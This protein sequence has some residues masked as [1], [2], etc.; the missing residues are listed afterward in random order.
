[1]VIYH[2]SERRPQPSMYA[3]S[4]NYFLP[5][6]PKVP[7]HQPSQPLIK[8]VKSRINRHKRRTQTANL[9][10]ADNFPQPQDS[11]QIQAFSEDGS[12]FYSVPNEVLVG[13]DVGTDWYPALFTAILSELLDLQNLNHAELPKWSRFLI[14]T[15]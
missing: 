7:S 15:S 11:I 14:S 2:R 4:R 10:V 13:C 12:P 5:T 1:M 6:S 3:A 9:S 8:V